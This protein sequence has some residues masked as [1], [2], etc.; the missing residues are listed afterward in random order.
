MKI[1][2]TSSKAQILFNIYWSFVTLLFG[3]A[4]NFFITPYISKHLGIEAYGF[5]NL[6]TTFVSYIDI[7]AVALNAFAARY[8][9]VAF[10]N[11]DYKAAEEFYSSVFVAN[12]VFI[13]FS[14]ILTSLFVVNMAKV[15]VIPEELVLDVKILFILVFVNYA[16]KLLANVFALTTFIKNQAGY[17]SRNNGIGKTIYA[18]VIIIFIVS[19]SIRL[20]SLIV[21]SLLSTAF[22]LFANFYRTRL[23]NNEISLKISS[24]SFQKVKLLISSGIW[25][26]VNNIGNMLN[27]G[28][29][30]LITNQL[31]SSV[32][33]GQI[34]VA[35]LLANIVASLSFLISNAFQPKQLEA[36]SQK[37]EGE[38]IKYLT[39]AMKIMGVLSGIIIAGFIAIGKQFYS[40]WMPTQNP[41]Y[42]YRLTII[43]LIGDVFVVVVRPLYYV[44]TLTDKL[45]VV[46][47][48][49]L[50]SGIINVAGMIVL[51]KMF[52]LGAY[53]VVGTTMILNLITSLFITPRLASIFLGLNNRIVF[54]NIVIRHSFATTLCTFVLMFFSKF[55]NTNAGWGNLIINILFLG[56]LGFFIMCLGELGVSECRTRYKALIQIIKDKM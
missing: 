20:Y 27:S 36:Y 32:M 38:L 56:I 5:I 29:D 48:I 37:D 50:L 12:I 34:S 13:I 23:Y 21:A 11:K 43:V 26:S 8:I 35:K 31:L 54:Q 51:I 33:M 45:R 40:T 52:G 42:L 15:L 10:H 2:N 19:N 49:T 16:L 28:L 55:L 17:T 4:I 24:F 6:G 18:V 22:V 3:Y 14:G 46:C 39:I 30:L 53:A 1:N 47:W 44:N 41:E 9:G 7:I 25:N